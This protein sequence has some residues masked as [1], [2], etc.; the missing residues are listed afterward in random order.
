MRR[1]KAGKAP[2]YRM[3]DDDD[4]PWGEWWPT[5]EQAIRKAMQRGCEHVWRVTQQGVTYMDTV[6]L[7]CGKTERESWD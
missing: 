1:I 5:P 2:E 6:C 7:K 4:D 3:R